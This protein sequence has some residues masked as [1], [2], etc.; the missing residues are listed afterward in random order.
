M[1]GERLKQARELSSMTQEQLAEIV[2]VEQTTI[3]R[4]ER[5]AFKP[6]DE[7]VELLATATRFPRDFFDLPVET[8]FPFGS[9]TYRKYAK[10][11]AEYKKLSHRLAQQ[12]FEL[13][14]LFAAKMKPINVG[15]P[16]SLD[17]D[18]V[19]AARIVRS[20]LGVDPTSPIKN[21]M[22]RIEKIGVRIFKLPVEIPDVDAFSIVVEGRTPVIAVNST[23]HGDRQNFSLAHELGHLVLHFPLTGRQDDIEVEANR[24]A[25]ELLLPE[26]AMRTEL[27]PPVTLTLLAELKTR[28]RVSMAAL[29]QRAKELDI[30][31]ERQHKYLRMQ[32]AQRDW[33]REEPVPIQPENPR[34]L[35][36]MA[37]VAYG[38]PSNVRKIAK[39]SKRPPFL[40]AQLLDMTVA[41]DGENGKILGFPKTEISKASENT[42]ASELA[43]A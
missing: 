41:T 6:R 17:E 26:E 34:V 7:L 3:A 43:E 32:L 35:R 33:L 39:T 13:S 18:P 37:E 11:K 15:L 36:K 30:V 28:W 14:E 29:L 19:S 38:T 40:V 25:G 27:V 42:K 5:D 2:G 10:T 8:E 16:R 24:F 1:I 31:T 12:A 21:L 4:I 23:R 20:A 9:L 22:Q